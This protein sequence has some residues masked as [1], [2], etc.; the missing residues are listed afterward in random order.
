MHIVVRS[1]RGDLELELLRDRPDAVV[2]ELL[3]A[4]DHGAV[5]RGATL[6]V[7]G[8][9][10]DSDLE[11]DEAGLVSGSLLELMEVGDPDWGT[12]E[13][14]CSATELAI[15]GGPAAGPAT[16]V[17]DSVVVVGRQVGLGVHLNDATVSPQ[18][19]RL[20]VSAAGALVE[21]LGSHNGVRIDG[22]PV[23]GSAKLGPGELVA[24]GAAEA[25]LQA[26]RVDDR[27]VGLDP[28]TMAV[29][30][31]LA[32]NR[33]PRAALAPEQAPVHVPDAPA[34]NKRKAV[35]SIA[36]LVGPILMGVVM[37]KLMGNI[38]FALFAVMSPVM[39]ISNYVATRRRNTKESKSSE[40]QFRSDL[41]EFRECLADSLD[42]ERARRERLVPDAAEV[43]RRAKLPSTRLW[44]RRH[45]HPDYLRLR[46]GR[47]PQDW[48][49]P[50]DRNRVGAA[51]R[52]QEAVAEASVIQRCAI[53]VDLAGGGVVGLVGERSAAL[54]LARSLVAQA[55]V[56]HGP[57]DMGLVILTDRL[58]APR[59]DWAKW[60]PHTLSPSGEGRLLCTDHGAAQELMDAFLAAA[61][62]QD[63]T[64]NL[65]LGGVTPSGPATL[66]VV[67]DETLLTGRR[68]PTRRVLRGKAGPI[69]GLVIA[70]TE[71]RLPAV[72]DTVVHLRDELGDAEL[73]RPQRGE[74]TVNIGIAGMTDATARLCAR[75]LARF[76]DPEIEIVGA[77]IPNTVKLLPL[78]GMD[79][80]DAAA[81][82]GRWAAAG[83]D[84][85]PSTPIGMSGDGLVEIDLVA[86]GPHALVGGT[87]GSGKSE[88]LRSLVAGMAARL[89][90]EQL[91][92]V[93]IDYKGGSAF[94]E[95]ARL[96][97]TVGM[98][99][100]LDEHLGQ[101]ALCSLEAELHRRE[102]LLRDNGATDLG[103]YLVAGAQAGP[104]PRLV[105]VVD[106][107][108]T[109]AAELPDFMGAL[110]GIAQRGR[111]LGVHM[112]LATQRP[113]GAVNANIKANTNMRIALRVQDPGDSVD[114]IDRPDAAKISRDTPGR[115]YVRLGPGDVIPV[116]TAL[117]TA[118]SRRGEAAPVSLAP[119]RFGPRSASG[120]EANIVEGDTDLVRLVDACVG[121][122]EANTMQSPRRPWLEMLPEHLPQHDLLDVNQGDHRVVLGLA[123]DPT[124]QCQLPVFWDPADGH[125]ALFGAV[126]SGTSSALVAAV[127][128][129][130]AVRPAGDLHVYCVDFGGGALGVLSAL[131]HVGAALGANERERQVR[132]VRFLVDE[133]DSRRDLARAEREAAP[134]LLV[135]IDGFAAFLAE[136]DG[137]EGQVVVDLIKRIMADGP[138]VGVTVALTGDRALSVPMRMMGTVTTRMLLRHTDPGDFA[139]AGI[140]PRDLPKFVPGRAVDAS[141]KLVVQLAYVDDPAETVE[142]LAKLATT[143]SVPPPIEAMPGSVDTAMVAQ[144]VAVGDALHLPVGIAEAD[145]QVCS[146]AL[147]PG[148][149]LFVAGQARSGVSTTLRMLARLMRDAHPE[150]VMVAVAESRSPL[151]GDT[152]L[153]DALGTVEQLTK[154]FELA[155][156]DTARE[157]ILMVDDAHG[158][159][160]PLGLGELIKSQHC[161]IVVGGRS[162]QLHGQFSHWTR[163]VRRSGTGLL[164]QPRL[165]ADGDLLGV[166]LPRRLTTPL[167]PGRGFLVSAGECTLVQVAGAELAA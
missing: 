145:H 57:A 73:R 46:V 31:L 144:H 42:K 133:I 14:A 80:V 155:A 111:S 34:P 77:G 109:M 37:V 15:V 87:T 104:M 7:D 38:R 29:G 142:E 164:L 91:V 83:T 151:S 50:V 157:W 102:R 30:G 112:I 58:N 59:W 132:L 113:S 135:A 115:A 141:S 22:E 64:A 159:E 150:A 107:F 120:V 125:L 43:L 45:T 2:G 40:R 149:H 4:I 17:G 23:R 13:A 51:D 16:D 154:V 82:S 114:V 124:H 25:V 128:A 52:L 74:R 65:A 127:L 55:C 85:P 119:F 48:L 165:D 26:A 86:D 101:R 94:D 33:P 67:D 79:E 8:R 1:P 81:V 110:V 53:E 89:S 99:T 21:D 123:D 103:E 10:V 98:V 3:A 68:A 39:F 12:G 106:E 146:V 70:A 122:F 116:Q 117:S 41:A 35:F 61:A 24:F 148:E 152:E 49:P 131:N 69:A 72:C 92:F 47:G 18:H 11:L 160:D 134:R 19:F 97:H 147:Y 90:P 108:A 60:L 93:L 158:I 139:S 167:V 162:E 78:L 88:F 156:V 96:P 161:R 56:F 95:C 54:A 76:E 75:N 28:T 36:T 143:G 163:G 121:A 32:F 136:F 100:D 9:P 6:T 62:D 105:L 71:D 118:S 63:K 5:S 126:G 153:F 137:L 84:P 166:R 140:R 66:L 44:E 130:A 20:T 138:G 27:P 129:A